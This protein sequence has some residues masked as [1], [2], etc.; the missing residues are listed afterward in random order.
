MEDQSTRRIEIDVRDLI[1]H[2]LGPDV[3]D[4]SVRVYVFGSD[5]D[6]EAKVSIVVTVKPP[7]EAPNGP[8]CLQ[9]VSHQRRL[10]FIR[11]RI[12]VQLPRNC[13]RRAG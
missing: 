9:S 1:R 4:A 3:G 7:G 2:A 13:R 8:Q 5:E 10:G 11:G 6:A 12:P